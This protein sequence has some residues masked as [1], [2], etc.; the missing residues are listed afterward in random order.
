VGGDRANL[1]TN[2]LVDLYYLRNAVLGIKPGTV[3]KI[4]LP[5]YVRNMKA[6]DALMT[7][8]NRAGIPFLAYIAPVRSDVPRLYGSA[9]Y[10]TWKEE[11]G[12]LCAEHTS[13]PRRANSGG[14][15]ISRC[16][17][18]FATISIFP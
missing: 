14:A 2:I 5:R 9:E 12:R 1:R 10:E 11:V 7:V 6:L 17:H 13:Q 8:M 4:I 18:G 16:H 15:G 3:R